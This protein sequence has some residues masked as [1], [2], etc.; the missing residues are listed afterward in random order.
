MSYR[1]KLSSFK[2]IYEGKYDTYIVCP[3]LFYAKSVIRDIELILD[4]QDLLERKGD[5]F[6]VLKKGNKISFRLDKPESFMG[7]PKHYFAT[8][9][10]IEKLTEEEFKNV[11]CNRW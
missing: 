7:L 11:G 10:T 1:I 2:D 9:D 3:K 5:W 6:L 4:K 8:L